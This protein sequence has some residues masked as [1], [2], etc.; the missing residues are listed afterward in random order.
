VSKQDKLDQNP[1]KLII[2]SYG[3]AVRALEEA[4]LAIEKG[5]FEAKIRNIDLAFGLISELRESLD[6]ETGGEIAEKL[7]SLYEFYQHE[8]IAA[9][10]N[11]DADRLTPIIDMMSS[12]QDAFMETQQKSEVSS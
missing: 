4:K 8:I 10:V 12:L 9:N 1:A 2:T 3:A 7:N 5:N 6:P 11:N